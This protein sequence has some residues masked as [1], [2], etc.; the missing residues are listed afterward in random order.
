MRQIVS[1]IRY[2]YKTTII[3]C[4]LKLDN[5]LVNFDDEKDR[6]SLNM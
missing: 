5:I 3:H 4:D 2:L 1:A 6:K